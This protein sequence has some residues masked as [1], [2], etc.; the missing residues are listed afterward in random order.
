MFK[1]W[2]EDLKHI[3]D[4]KTVNKENNYELQIDDNLITIEDSSMC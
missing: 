4:Q 3:I 2:N 1:T